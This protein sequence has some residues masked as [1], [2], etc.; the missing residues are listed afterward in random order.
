MVWYGMVTRRDWLL[1]FFAAAS[2]LLFCLGLLDVGFVGVVVI[3]HWKM[4][5]NGEF[6][7]VLCWEGVWNMEDE[8]LREFG[9]EVEKGG[10]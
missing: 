6:V 2:A 1:P 7:W 4:L 8:T 9:R 3:P 10:R 5:G